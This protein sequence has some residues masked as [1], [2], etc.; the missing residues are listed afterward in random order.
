MANK[1]YAFNETLC[2]CGCGVVRAGPGAKEYK[3]QF[4]FAVC[5]VVRDGKAVVKALVVPVVPWWLRWLISPR[6]F[7]RDYYKAIEDVIPA[8]ISHKSER[9]K[10][11]K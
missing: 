11:G 10:H 2:A 6:P 3:D 1:I 8:P 9:Y 7:T 5:Y 4:D